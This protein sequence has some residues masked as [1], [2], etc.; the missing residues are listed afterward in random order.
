M[1][2]VFEKNVSKKIVNR[3]NPNCI[4]AYVRIGLDNKQG[5]EN[6]NTAR[7]QSYAEKSNNRRYLRGKFSLAH[8]FMALF[9]M[10]LCLI[11][12][13]APNFLLNRHPEEQGMGKQR[14]RRMP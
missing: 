2:Q 10:L 12:S 5:K 13:V 6:I 4:R 8:S 11:F 7:V 9:L 1:P 14:M 3:F